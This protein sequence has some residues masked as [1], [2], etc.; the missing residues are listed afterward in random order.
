MMEDTPANYND[1]NQ[2][3]EGRGKSREGPRGNDGMSGNDDLEDYD[4]EMDD[5]GDD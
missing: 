4:M 3:F 1:Q 2:R 5:F